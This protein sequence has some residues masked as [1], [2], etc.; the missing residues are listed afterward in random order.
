M[1]TNRKE[2]PCTPLRN[3]LSSFAQ[4][5]LLLLL[6]CNRIVKH[7]DFNNFPSGFFF[8]PNSQNN[9]ESFCL[10]LFRESGLIWA[11]QD[12]APMLNQHRKLEL[13]LYPWHLLPI[14]KLYH[15]FWANFTNCVVISSTVF[16]TVA[17]FLL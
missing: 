5:N 8:P 12:P 9:E 4:C 6:R 1:A 11:H 14:D 10:L 17:A 3:K 15:P 2:T 13:Y 16:N 7:L